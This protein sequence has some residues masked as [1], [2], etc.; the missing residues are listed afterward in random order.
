MR[1]LVITQRWYPDTFGGSEHVAAE[2]A[3]RLAGRGHT[4]DVLTQRVRDLL[5]EVERSPLNL[6]LVKGEKEGVGSLTI[7][8]YGSE[9]QFARPAGLSRTDVKEVHE[10]L[11]KTPPQ[12]P[13]FQGGE[14]R[15][16]DVAI[17]HH[18]FPAYGFFKAGLHVPSLYLFH[19]STAK[20]AAFERT[21]R[22]PFLTRLFVRW[23]Y[24]VERSV[25]TRASR[26]AVLSDFST[27][28]LKETYPNV[29][30]KILK[31]PIGID[32]E[33]FV[34]ADRGAAKERLGFSRDRTLLL[35]VRRFSPRMGLS[36]LIHAMEAV[37]QTAPHAQLLIVG[38]GP[39]KAAL[40]AEIE[41]HGLQGK[42][43]L[44][45][46]VPR[47][48][49]PLYFQAADLFVLPT[50]AFEGLGMATLEALASGLPVLGTPAGATPEVLSDLDLTL[51]AKSTSAEDI[52]AGIRTYL[53]RPEAQ[54]A[55]L[56]KKA[57]ELAVA[58]YNWERA[59]DSLEE[60]LK[61]L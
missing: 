5:P 17:L 39:L 12:S 37:V 4:V 41:L 13:P 50:A 36:T 25:L 27:S 19:A 49:I 31:L 21:K 45:G 47:E 1:I 3:R 34:P 33:T 28:V 2:Q 10:F 6:P 11:R 44:V 42:V 15:G 54:R 61:S 9:R 55:A 56:G 29:Q 30:E 38:E 40:Q 43:T 24:R 60:V 48:D 18:P 53:A 46:A 35:T 26:I 51:I 52:A 58:K 20:E 7:Y 16:W 59:T 14:R 32:T 57:R 8:R 22:W 23:A